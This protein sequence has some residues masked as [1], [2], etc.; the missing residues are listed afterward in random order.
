MGERVKV[1]DKIESGHFPVV[2]WIKGGGRGS[3]GKGRE[4]EEIEVAEEGRREFREKMERL[5]QNKVEKE[6]VG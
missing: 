2:M 1:E 3:E 5:W 6:E 4:E